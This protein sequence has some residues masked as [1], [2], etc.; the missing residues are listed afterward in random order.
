LL[1]LIF[2]R[3]ILKFKKV[4]WKSNVKIL[5]T[6]TLCL[7]IAS[8]CNFGLPKILKSE[9]DPTAKFSS[10]LPFFHDIAYAIA[11][12]PNHVPESA[13]IDIYKV[14]GQEGVE[15]SLNCGSIWAIAASP[16]FDWAKGDEIASDVMQNWI[17]TLKSSASGSLLRGHF[18]RTSAFIPFPIS[19]G[20]S[21]GWVWTNLGINNDS[22]YSLK[23]ELVFPKV[24]E[25]GN[26]LNTS[27]LTNFYLINWPGFVFSFVLVNFFVRKKRTRVE[28]GLVLVSSIRE[29]ILVVLAPSQE[30]RFAFLLYICGYVYLCKLLNDIFEKTRPKY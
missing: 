2:I 6:I 27:L 24:T 15:A 3:G 7:T 16:G 9:P 18:C 4:S 8:F 29:L 17:K 25:L 28:T 1:L 26:Y 30:F 22:G 20:P 5:S 23:Q 14:I 21:P 19:L 13:K 10:V 11:K 12:D